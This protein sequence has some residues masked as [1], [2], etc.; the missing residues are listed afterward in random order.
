M[1]TTTRCSRTNCRTRGASTP[2]GPTPRAAVGGSDSRGSS[3]RATSRARCCSDCAAGGLAPSP[4]DST[5]R[6]GGISAS[7]ASSLRR[8]TSDRSSADRSVRTMSS[9]WATH[10]EFG[11]THPPLWITGGLQRSA[12]PVRTGS[13]PDVPDRCTCRAPSPQRE[14][15]SRLRVAHTPSAVRAPSSGLVAGS[16]SKARQPAWLPSPELHRSVLARVTTGATLRRRVRA[17]ACRLVVERG[18]QPF[19]QFIPVARRHHR[20]IEVLEHLLEAG[21]DAEQVHLLQAHRL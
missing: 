19:A 7:N 10:R 2:N 1:P 21:S 3:W 6:R 15:L 9:P 12:A 4:V 8:T 17:L 11:Q 18:A 13:R 16:T 20:R 14:Y 5:I